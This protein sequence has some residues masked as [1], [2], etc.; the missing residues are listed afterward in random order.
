MCLA[1][2]AI[3]VGQ[4]EGNATVEIIGTVVARDPILPALGMPIC[5]CSSESL[6]VRIDTGSRDKE[7]IR[8]YFTGSYFTREL[9]DALLTK[10]HRWRLHVTR[11]PTCDGPVAVETVSSGKAQ[12]APAAPNRLLVH[13][14]LS[15][16]EGETIPEGHN[17]QC[18]R[19][20]PRDVSKL[21]QLDDAAATPN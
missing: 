10:A 3:A 12:G 15:G 6:V 14:L 21:Q 18:Y 1:G 9:P 7:Y 2:T 11:M 19:L 5:D 4:G 20:N 8:I 17:L 16:A 13:R